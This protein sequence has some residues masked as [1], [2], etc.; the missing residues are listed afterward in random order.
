MKVKEPQPQ[1]I[2][3]RSGNKSFVVLKVSE[4]EQMLADLHDLA[5]MAERRTEDAVPLS[6]FERELRAEGRI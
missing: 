5:L 6:E 2:V 4:Y 3:D 1:Y